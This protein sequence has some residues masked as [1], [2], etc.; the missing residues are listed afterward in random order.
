MDPEALVGASFDSKG[1][2]AVG[3]ALLAGQ[4][5]PEGRLL[6][7]GYLYPTIAASLHSILPRA[8]ILFQT[9]CVGA[10]LLF[11]LRA[12]RQIAGR[13]MFAPMALLSISL[14]IAPANIMP[15]AVT[16]LF[17]AMGLFL[18]LCPQ[19]SV[20]APVALTAGALVKPALL[21]VAFVSLAL[22]FLRGRRGL[23]PL[24]A[25]LCL[26]APQVLLTYHF[27]GQVVLSNSGKANFQERFY[28]AVAGWIE[29]GEFVSYRADL[30]SE[31]RT[32]RPSLTEEV[33]YV[34]RHP[35]GTLSAWAMILWNHHLT[36]GSGFAANDNAVAVPERREIIETI[37]F[38]LN[39]AIFVLLVP[40][41]VGAGRFVLSAS[42]WSWPAAL[43][44][45][46]LIALA[47]LVYWRGDRII[48][49]GVLLM[50]PFVSLALVR[51]QDRLL[52]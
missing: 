40:A 2:F 19:G 8:L 51:P 21:P 46:S 9:V 47:P 13:V 39:A 28:P 41:L 24:S 4:E 10:G 26:L 11:L 48:F 49:E 22:L 32:E 34:S 1:Y 14:L 3:K 31:L 43:V 38:W 5:P 15:E 20:W 25:A 7:R 6:Q 36:E 23:I 17:A 27:N 12:E 52:D 29:T 45:P 37:S 16:F 50:L 44:G 18:F 33:L 35:L 42:P 30:A